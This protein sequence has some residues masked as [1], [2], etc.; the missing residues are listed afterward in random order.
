M[1][2][3]MPTKVYSEKNAVKNHAKELAALG[4]K[5]L[6]MTGKHSS[7]SNGSLQDV[8]DAL[9]AEGREYC[10]FDEVE[11]NPSVELAQRAAEFGKQ[12]GADFVIGIGGGS[13]LDCAKAVA[14]LIKNPDRD[15]SVFYQKVE[16]EAVPVAA[17]P[18]TAGTGSEV[19]PYAILTRHDKQT[20][21]SIVQ[22]VFPEIALVDSSY[23]AT[24]PVQVRIN[25]AVDAL[26]HLLESWINTNASDYSK[27]LCE[28]GL[29]IFFD[30]W[31]KLSSEAE[32]ESF[33]KRQGESL[34]EKHTNDL[35]YFEKLMTISTIAGM[36][37]S[38]TGTSLPHGM[39]YFLTYHH[40]VPHGKAVGVFLGAYL[41]EYSDKKS[42]EYLL[43][44]MGFS[45]LEEF[46]QFLSGILGE[47]AITQ[48][49]AWEYADS[50][51]SNKAKLANCPYEVTGE[52]MRRMFAVVL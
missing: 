37:I 29:K 30:V 13:P 4:I 8:I 10:I 26:A 38:H 15:S 39:S 2:F 33:A 6:I 3:Y 23:L 52:M 35:E 50:M 51:M 44:L 18:T 46:S 36:A 14:F 45:D 11:E 17:V 28:Y 20:K 22:K 12:A 32:K 42:M 9:D 34:E 19:T 16:L 1:K 25:T 27:M 48:K 47:V 41:R 49:E 43:S 24:E 21:Q 7:R 5:A 31:S 40:G